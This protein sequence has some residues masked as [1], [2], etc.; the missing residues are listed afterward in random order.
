MRARR[1]GGGPRCAGR[2]ADEA[3]RRRETSRRHG[4][5]A[6]GHSRT[7]DWE[8]DGLLQLWAALA[9]VCSSDRRH[10]HR[11][12]HGPPCAS[13]VRESRLPAASHELSDGRGRVGLRVRRDRDLLDSVYRR[14]QGFQIAI[15]AE[16]TPVRRGE[17]G[18]IAAATSSTS[19]RT[20]GTITWEHGEETPTER[21]VRRIGSTPS[22]ACATH[23]AY[24]LRRSSWC[25]LAWSSCRRRSSGL[26]NLLRAAPAIGTSSTSTTSLIDGTPCASPQLSSKWKWPGLQPLRSQ[27]VPRRSRLP[28]PHAHPPTGTAR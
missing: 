2:G 5:R 1:D 14:P 26:D 17:R 15:D 25:A 27:P 3:R 23:G 21:W 8:T 13:S 12:P 22:I 20:R 16:R 6:G 4:S 19:C 9:T 18:T 28:Q 11:G 24:R 10:G 7:P